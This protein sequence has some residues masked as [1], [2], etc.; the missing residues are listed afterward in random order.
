MVYSVCSSGSTLDCCF[1]SCVSKEIDIAFSDDVVP[2]FCT[3]RKMGPTTNR[4]CASIGY[5]RRTATLLNGGNAFAAHPTASTAAPPPPLPPLLLL[6]LLPKLY[7]NNDATASADPGDLEPRVAV[8]FAAIS[9]LVWLLEL[10]STP[11][12]TNKAKSVGRGRFTEDAA[13]LAV[14]VEPAPVAAAAAVT[15]L[16]EPVLAAELA[17]A[18]RAQSTT[19]R[20]VPACRRWITLKP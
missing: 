19:A 3:N 5:A 11:A 13:V 9:T 16:P 14:A 18:L 10:Q 6:F 1:H 4:C 15:A 7:T 12:A 2:R 8:T 17:V 20:G